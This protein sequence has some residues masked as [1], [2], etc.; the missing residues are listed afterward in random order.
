LAQGVGSEFKP[1]YYNNNN[2]KKDPWWKTYSSVFLS[3]SFHK[4]E[5]LEM[6][7]FRKINEFP[8]HQTL[9]WKNENFLQFKSLLSWFG[10][11]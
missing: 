2:N 7:Y 1:Q 9:A 5:I 11:K 4:A 6:L 3:G 10:D 8:V